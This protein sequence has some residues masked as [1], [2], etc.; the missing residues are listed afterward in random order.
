MKDN[1]SQDEGFKQLTGREDDTWAGL[2]NMEAKCVGGT[3]SISSNDD[4][5]GESNRY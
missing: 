4:Y 1:Q 5:R 3:T 2:V